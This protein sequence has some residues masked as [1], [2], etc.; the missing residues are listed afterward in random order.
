VV[1]G[2]FN[3]VAFSTGSAR[4]E[5]NLVDNYQKNG[6]VVG[7]SGSNAVIAANRVL[8]F[9]PSSTIGQNGIE[10]IQDATAEV[11]HNFTSGHQFTLQFVTPVRVLLISAGTVDI[12]HTP[13]R[14][15]TAMCTHSCRQQPPPGPA[16]PAAPARRRVRS[17]PEPLAI[18]L[19]GESRV[20]P[21]RGGVADRDDH[22]WKHYLWSRKRWGVTCCATLQNAPRASVLPDSH[23]TADF[24]HMLAG[25]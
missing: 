5:G 8:G 24:G 14:R 19:G 20:D 22:C 12:H 11:K 1:G 21:Q 4:I 17:P 10:V 7:G 23:M 16:R 15:M 9:G 3:D 25:A 6:V 2:H 18:G 13:S